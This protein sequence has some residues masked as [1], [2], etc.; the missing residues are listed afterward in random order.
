MHD[1]GRSNKRYW[2]HNFYL[3]FRSWLAA[4]DLIYP[5]LISII[6]LVR[7]RQRNLLASLDNDI[8]I[9]GFPRSANTY[10]VSFFELA[11]GRPLSIGHHLHESWQ[12]RFA[13]RHNI[14][15][16]VLIREP[17]DAVCSAILRDPRANAETSLKNYIRLYQNILSNRQCSVIA[18]FE[19]IINDSNQ[20]IAQVNKVYGTDFQTLPK[21]KLDLVAKAVKRKDQNDF[22]SKNLDP[23]RIAAPSKEKRSA[24]LLMREK[25]KESN[26]GL[27]KTA[28]IIYQEVCKCRN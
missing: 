11:Q 22:G 6:G 27:L 25:V 13:E 20:I 1:R 9:D 23:M 4:S 19:V 17:L 24:G 28:G 2:L 3:R 21:E 18:P 5:K 26:G 10:F 15:C 14:P 7:P 8:V 12:F 16:V